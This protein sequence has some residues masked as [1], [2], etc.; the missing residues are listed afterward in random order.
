MACIDE[1]GIQYWPIMIS[2][3]AW[4]QTKVWLHKRPSIFLL[5]GSSSGLWEERME[6][7][8]CKTKWFRSEFLRHDDVIKRKHFLRYWLFVRVI[9]RSSVH[10]THKGQRRGVL[11]FLWSEPGQTVQQTLKT[12]V[13][14]PSCT[15]VLAIKIHSDGCIVVACAKFCSVMVNG[16][17][18]TLFYI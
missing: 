15:Q 12:P 6:F 9:H 18:V 4:I 5:V 17:G 2:K 16:N 7:T 1:L 11:I 3:K 10:S 13:I 14:C 8:G